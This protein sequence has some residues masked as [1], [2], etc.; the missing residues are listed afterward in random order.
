MFMELWM[1]RE[2]L[3]CASP[4][5]LWKQAWNGHWAMVILLVEEVLSIIRGSPSA[6]D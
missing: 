6:R 5:A 4:L 2:V 1:N 3:D